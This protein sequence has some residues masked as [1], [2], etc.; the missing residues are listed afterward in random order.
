M[1]R[2]RDD[3]RTLPATAPP[4]ALASRSHRSAF[5]PRVTGAVPIEEADH[6]PTTRHSTAIRPS[7]K[8]PIASTRFA[9]SS[10]SRRLHRWPNWRT[11]GRRRAGSNLWGAVPV[12]QE[13][14]AEGGAAGAVH[15][16]LQAG[17][18]TTTFTASQG[19]LLMIPNMFKIA[20]ELT[21]CV[22]HVAARSI[23]TQALVDLRRPFGCHGGP[24]DRLRPLERGLG[25]RGA[26]SRTRGAGGDA[27]GA[28]A[29]RPFHG[30]ISYL[31]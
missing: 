14:Q 6:G 13:M 30:W 15:G 18:L 25:A 7:P 31:A 20:G 8:L 16:S 4:D 5:A 3:A 2:H 26:R 24:R 19:L 28:R 1:P 27:R 29:V 12:V 22:F 10:R 23:G 21:P 9:R 11:N 17:A